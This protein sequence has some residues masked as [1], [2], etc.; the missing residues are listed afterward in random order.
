DLEHSLS[1]SYVRGIVQSSATTWATMAAAPNEN[2]NTYD[3]LLTFGLI[4]FDRNRSSSKTQ[5]ASGLRLFLPE[6]AV[7]TTCHRLAA[8]SP[9]VRIELYEYSP[10]SGRIRRCDSVVAGNVQS[11][12]AQRRET[13]AALD[14]ARAFLDYLRH[15]IPDA[16]QAQP[17]SG[18]GFLDIRYRGMTFA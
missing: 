1:G 17:I 4:W 15:D 10:Q 3:A 2:S 11:W 8:L 18:T 13:E 7:R 14:S 9:S 16:I 6:G 12:L 5:A